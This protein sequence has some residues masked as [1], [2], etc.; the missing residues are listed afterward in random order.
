M[1]ALAI[2]ERFDV[3]ED[4]R[5][6]LGAGVKKGSVPSI[7]NISFFGAL[8]WTIFGLQAA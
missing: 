7:V 8:Q 2:I 5:A 3:I 1:G 6:S 4:L